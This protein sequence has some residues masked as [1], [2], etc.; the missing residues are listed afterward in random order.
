MLGVPIVQN[1]SLSGICEDVHQL[2]I[3]L[4]SNLR[5]VKMTF[6]K[7]PSK[8]LEKKCSSPDYPITDG[9]PLDIDLLSP[10]RPWC[11]ANEP[12]EHAKGPTVDLTTSPRL[13]QD[14]Q[15]PPWNKTPKTPTTLID[16]PE[17]TTKTAATEDG[18]RVK[19][20]AQ[21]LDSFGTQ[22]FKPVKPGIPKSWEPLG[23]DDVPNSSQTHEG[24][25]QTVSSEACV[26]CTRATESNF[27]VNL[28][29]SPDHSSV[30]D[31]AE[32][33]KLNYNSPRPTLRRLKVFE[34][35]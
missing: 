7:K 14:A 13:L 1:Q 5:H 31:V 34:S 18:D 24:L 23:G 15:T 29:G 17:D 8:I 19:T 35:A 2:H 9:L 21:G 12:V 10:L 6:L 26:T 30:G 22:T 20:S 3:T 32:N 33:S 16:D 4:L 28:H 25:G 27:K 11:D